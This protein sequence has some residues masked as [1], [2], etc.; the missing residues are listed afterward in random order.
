VSPTGLKWAAPAAGGKVL[1]VIQDTEST[2]VATVSSTYVDTGLSVTITPS[3]ASNKVLI[4]VTS[5]CIKNNEANQSIQLELDRGGT[6]IQVIHPGLYY[7][8]P[9]AAQ[10]RGNFAMNFLDSPATTSAT[11]Y[12]VRVRAANN[13]GNIEVATQGVSTIT[14]LEIGA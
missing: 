6:Q 8:Y 10:I 11:T 7:T 1:Q 5:N 2:G 12:K 14:A 3:S 4:M 9:T 13:S